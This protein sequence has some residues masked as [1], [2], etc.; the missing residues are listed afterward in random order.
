MLQVA[1]EPVRVHAVDAASSLD[2]DVLHDHRVR[3]VLADL[4]E[5]AAVRR[6]ARWTGCVS[7]NVAEHLADPAAHLA[8]CDRVLRPG[9]LLVLAHSDWDTALFSRDDDDATRAAGRPVRLRRC[10]A[11]PSAPTASWAASCSSSR[12]ASPFELVSLDTWADPHRRFDQ[13]SVAWKV[14]MGVLPPSRTTP[15]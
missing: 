2:D 5:T 1:A 3:S 4:D 11:G 8:D 6:T 15:S 13:G 9:G 12:P 7:L 10:R 14:A